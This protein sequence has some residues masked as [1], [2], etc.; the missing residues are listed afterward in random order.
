MIIFQALNSAIVSGIS[1]TSGLRWRMKTGNP[2]SDDV[3]FIDSR[4]LLLILFVIVRLIKRKR[5]NR[6]RFNM[7]NKVVNGIKDKYRQEPNI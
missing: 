1:K 6:Y 3:S 2:V 4:N 5:N 7:V